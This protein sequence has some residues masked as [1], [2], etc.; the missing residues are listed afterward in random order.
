MSSAANGADM[1]W[2]TVLK[3]LSLKLVHISPIPKIVALLMKTW[4]TSIFLIAIYN[5]RGVVQSNSIHRADAFTFTGPILRLP[6]VALHPYKAAGHLVAYWK[7]IDLISFVIGP[8]KRK[9]Y[10]RHQCIGADAAA[11]QH[12]EAFSRETGRESVVLRPVGED[13]NSHLRGIRVR[14]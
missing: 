8:D 14:W 2:W 11:L 4:G 12:R 10:A 3:T 5:K 7:L 6:A 1:R 13:L 9:Y